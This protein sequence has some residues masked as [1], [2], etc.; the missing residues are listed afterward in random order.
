[1]HIFLSISTLHHSFTKKLCFR[2]F[3]HG[4][5][6]KGEPFFT[7]AGVPMLVKWPEKIKKGKIVETAY[8]SIDFAP[9]LLGLL[10]I[11][12]LPDGMNMH[13]VDGSNEILNNLDI[14]SDDSKIVFSYRSSGRW[15]AAIKDG[16]KLVLNKKYKSDGPYLFDL[17]IDPDELMN[18]A[19]SASHKQI[20]EELKK[21][22]IGWIYEYKFLDA[23][24]INLY[25]DTPSCIDSKNVLHY[26]GTSNHLPDLIFCNDVGSK[27]IS[28]EVCL[29]DEIR[30][31]CPVTCKSRCPDSDGTMMFRN[32]VAQCRELR[33]GCYDERVR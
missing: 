20:F 4:K 29:I 12:D 30:K 15:I 28:Q 13:G 21:A 19:N 2:S 27:K 17:N 24:K 23:D 10:N 31:H 22:L 33:D 1:M 3:E 14:S 11:T 7:S 32:K 9:T 5:S 18:F 8:S 26:E 6:N 25:L 16:Y